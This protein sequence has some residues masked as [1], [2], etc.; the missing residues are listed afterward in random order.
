M[1]VHCQ[2]EPYVLHCD[3]LQY[4]VHTATLEPE[5]YCPDGYRLDIYPGNNI[6][7]NRAIL[8]DADG[9]K[10]IT[11]LWS[12]YSKK[13]SPYLMTVQVANYY[14]YCD[15]I[16]WADRLL[17]E[18]VDCVYNS[19]GRFDICCDFECDRATFLKIRKLA[20]G[21]AYVERKSVDS[22]FRH[23]YAWGPNETPILS[24][25]CLH[26]GQPST[27]I[28]PKLYNKTFEQDPLGKCQYEKP[29]IIERWKEAGLDIRHVWRLE[30]S[31]TGASTLMVNGDKVTLE[32][33]TNSQWLLDT[34]CSFLNERFRCR[35]NDGRRTKREN[36]DR[37]MWLIFLGRSKATIDWRLTG[38]KKSPKSES[39]K[40]LHK[41]IAMLESPVTTVNMD[42]YKSI[43]NVIFTLCENRDVNTYF[44]ARYGLPVGAYLS[45]LQRDTGLGAHWSE[46]KLNQKFDRPCLPSSERKTPNDS[47]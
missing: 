16:M 19:M 36:N 11:L 38:E 40:L 37:R 15:G 5:L 9:Q 18:V 14:L 33:I 26:Y 43:S 6:F 20:S 25:H 10:I 3:W 44:E 17:H 1:I 4:S 13:L 7:R 8:S 23:K 35:Y 21:A 47:H 28:R 27:E 46:P 22:L 24:P 45:L 34:Y 12:P 2:G 41:M 39:I 42:V 32:H 29:Y 31:V 30:F